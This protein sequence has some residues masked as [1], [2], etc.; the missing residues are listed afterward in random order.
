LWYF[1]NISRILKDRRHIDE[2]SWVSYKKDKGSCHP[3]KARLLLLA[4]SPCLVPVL[5][6]PYDL[7]MNGKKENITGRDFFCRD[8]AAVARALLG[9]VLVSDR[10]PGLAAGII[11]ETEAYYGTGDPASHAF[12]GMTPRSSIMFGKAGAAYIYLCYGVYW[13]L[14]VVT[15]KEG[16]PGA[17]LI[18]AVRPLRGIEVMQQRRGCA[19]LRGLADGPGKLTIA[20]GID[21]CD[22]GTDMALPGSSLYFTQEYAGRVFDIEN[23]ARIGITGGKDRLLRFVAVGL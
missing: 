9:K 7:E 23:T 10:P 13:L 19:G 3:R 18:R 6:L 14:N 20:M 22:N 8:T 15:E 1:L 11:T 4:G 12:R 5:I 17:V 16:I 21:G 2:R